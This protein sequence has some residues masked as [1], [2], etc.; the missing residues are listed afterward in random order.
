MRSLA[1]DR[2]AWTPPVL[3]LF[4]AVGNHRANDVWE[5][6]A[7]TRSLLSST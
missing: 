1:L 5:A 4:A 6:G 2:D 7:Y 3:A